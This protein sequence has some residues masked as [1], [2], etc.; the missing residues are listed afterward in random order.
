MQTAPGQQLKETLIESM[1]GFIRARCGENAIP[2]L[3][4][5]Q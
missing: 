2:T 1:H 5:N 4:K 3:L